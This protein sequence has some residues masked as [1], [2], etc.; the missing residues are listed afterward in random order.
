MAFSKKAGGH[1]VS[2]YLPMEG[3]SGVLISYAYKNLE[4]ILPE[5]LHV[6]KEC[7]LIIDS[8]AF[9]AHSTGKTIRL[10][11][12]AEWAIAF[13]KH[14]RNKLTSLEF[15]NLD[16]IGDQ[17]KSQVNLHKIESMG[18]RPLP[19]FT[20]KADLSIL[21]GLLERYEYIALGGL[22]D[23]PNLQK[24]LDACFFRVMKYHKKNGIVRKIHLLGVTTDWILRRYPCYTS[25]SSSWTQGFRFSGGVKVWLKQGGIKADGIPLCSEGESAVN[26]NIHLM[27]ASIR[28]YKKMQ[29]EATK[30]WTSRGITW[31]D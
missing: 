21:D 18:L 2:Q 4:K 25:D 8:G 1:L 19:I 15:M 24:W 11:E 28:H 9:T 13:D 22:F 30:L 5:M 26:I 17:E 3:I 7:H 27:R 6:S 14:W 12:Y 23:K 29:D 31:N 20:Y 10:E 16:V